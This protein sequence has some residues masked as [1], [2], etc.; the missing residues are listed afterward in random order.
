MHWCVFFYQCGRELAVSIL[1][2]VEQ[3]SSSS[4][5]TDAL[6]ACSPRSS[7][8]KSSHKLRSLE[9]KSINCF[10]RLPA[11]QYNSLS[12]VKLWLRQFLT[13]S[14]LTVPHFSPQGHRATSK[15][16]P[17]ST[18]PSTRASR[19]KLS[20]GGNSLISPSGLDKMSPKQLRSRS[21]SRGRKL[22]FSSVD[23]E[24]RE[25]IAGSSKHGLGGAPKSKSYKGKSLS[26]KKSSLTFTDIVEGKIPNK[27]EKKLKV[28][29]KHG[30]TQSVSLTPNFN[31]NLSVSDTPESPKMVKKVEKVRRSSKGI[32]GS[33]KKLKKDHL[34]RSSSDKDVPEIL[35]LKGPDPASGSS[36]MSSPRSPLSCVFQGEPSSSA[37][38]IQKLPVKRRS[39]VSLSKSMDVL[40]SI[41]GTEAPSSKSPSGD[42]SLQGTNLSAALS[43][44]DLNNPKV[45]I[46]ILLR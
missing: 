40:P 1:D 16:S 32:G 20:K 25:P 39:K 18:S 17:F 41:L 46:I 43:S 26:P 27:G 13:S 37:I 44:P 36:F 34:K 9:S 14:G 11:C 23:A 4:L 19:F 2:S 21:L 6:S 12:G 31:V 3:S 28:R 38:K 24:N 22:S 10:S 29:A 8:S 42:L 35:D 33:V 30:L 5:L 45:I 7:N 15:L